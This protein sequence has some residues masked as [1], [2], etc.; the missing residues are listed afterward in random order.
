MGMAYHE[1]FSDRPPAAITSQY[2]LTESRLKKM[3]EDAFVAGYESP[4]EF[5]R[6]EVDRILREPVEEAQKKAKESAAAA[7]STKKKVVSGRETFIDTDVVLREAARHQWK[8]ET[9]YKASGASDY[10]PGPP[11][12]P[13][14]P[15]PREVG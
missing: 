4:I 2:A 15:K 12:P 8:F 11:D 5:M 14:P 9:S 3:L 7:P 1:V 10:V 13:K 6:Q